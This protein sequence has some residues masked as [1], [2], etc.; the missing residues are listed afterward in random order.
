LKLTSAGPNR[1]DEALAAFVSMTKARQFS[2]KP[3]WH[4]PGD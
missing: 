1:S 2:T 4:A 3:R